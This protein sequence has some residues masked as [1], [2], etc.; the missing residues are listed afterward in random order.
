M[1]FAIIA[2][3][4]GIAACGAPPAMA[5]ACTPQFTVCAVDEANTGIDSRWVAR[6]LA[7]DWNAHV[8]VDCENPD[9]FLT[10]VHLGYG[11]AEWHPSGWIYEVGGPIW[12]DA[13][14]LGQPDGMARFRAAIDH[15]V[16]HVFNMQHV[17]YPSVMSVRGQYMPTLN[18]WTRLAEILCQP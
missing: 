13:R 14:V 5:H 18:D 2:L 8:S 3:I 10:I 16:G 4:L 11:R 17:E 12:V 9:V 1:R 7:G 15:E 6:L